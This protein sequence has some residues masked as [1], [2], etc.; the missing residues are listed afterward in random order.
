MPISRNTEIPTY[1]MDRKTNVQIVQL[2]DLPLNQFRDLRKFQRAT[3]QTDEYT[4]T[5][6]LEGADLQIVR[7]SV[8][9]RYTSILTERHSEMKIN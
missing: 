5:R 6:I 9:L 3:I 8:F 4:N 2:T 1:S 7:V